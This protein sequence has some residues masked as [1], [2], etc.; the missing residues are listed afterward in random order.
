MKNKQRDKQ[1]RLKKAAIVKV[2]YKL[3]AGKLDDGFKM[4]FDGVLKD[5]DLEES[6]VDGYIESHA[7][8]IKK[9]CSK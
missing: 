3:M 7:Q 1:D 5:L 6:E 4:I 2:K 8:E 9:I